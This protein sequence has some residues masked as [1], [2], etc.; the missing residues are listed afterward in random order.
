MAEDGNDDK[1]A[2]KSVG[3]SHAFR[4]NSEAIKMV[5]QNNL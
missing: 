1:G 5:V 2:K 4:K 3:S